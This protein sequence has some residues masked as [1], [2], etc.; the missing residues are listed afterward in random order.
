MMGGYKLRSHEIK[1]SF[2]HHCVSVAHFT[3]EISRNFFSK[4]DWGNIGEVMNGNQDVC[5]FVRKNR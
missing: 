3:R 4:V 5:T 1:N 2:R